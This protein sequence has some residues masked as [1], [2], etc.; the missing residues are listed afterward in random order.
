MD[1]KEKL[2]NDT[3]NTAN[4]EAQADKPSPSNRANQ[5]MSAG[6]CAKDQKRVELAQE[7]FVRLASL[8]YNYEYKYALMLG[9]AMSLEKEIELLK[10]QLSYQESSFKKPLSDSFNV[11]KTIK[12][13]EEAA[14]RNNLKNLNAILNSFSSSFHLYMDSQK[15]FEPR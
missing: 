6:D 1:E 2:I 10:R 7:M 5:A 9:K 15:V 4:K 14:K 3:W 12:E 8:E 13:N 11:E